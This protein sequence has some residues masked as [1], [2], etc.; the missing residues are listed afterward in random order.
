MKA[1]QVTPVFKKKS[2]LDKANY[3]P[4]SILPTLSKIFEGGAGRSIDRSL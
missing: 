1:A 2:P 3:R 4:V